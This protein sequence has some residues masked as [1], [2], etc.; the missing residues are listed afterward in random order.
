MTQARQAGIVDLL[1]DTIHL[2]IL[3]D[4]GYQ[5]LVGQTCGQVVTPP[6][7][8]RGK[9]LEHVQWLMAHHEAARFAHSSARI[10]V[11]HGIAHLKNWRSLARHHG[12]HEHL[13]QTLQAVAALLTTQQTADRTPTPDLR[14]GRPR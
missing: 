14:P 12:R 3:A 8:R 11:E 10:P 5:G 6:R 4:A 13:P 7:K 2:R 9:H 1:A